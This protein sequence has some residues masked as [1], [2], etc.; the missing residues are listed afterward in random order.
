MFAVSNTRSVANV[1]GFTGTGMGT[2]SSGSDDDVESKSLRSK[3]TLK[4]A[5]QLLSAEEVERVIRNACKFDSQ[6]GLTCCWYA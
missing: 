3:L 2:S 1:V 6:R 5:I 4:P